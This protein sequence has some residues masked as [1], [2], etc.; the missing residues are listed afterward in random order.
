MSVTTDAAT[1]LEQHRPALTGHCYRMLGSIGDADDAVQETL[2]RAWRSFDRFEGRSSLRHWLV[3]IATHVCLDAL[4]ARARRF[5]AIEL[6]PPGGVDDALGTRPDHDWLEPAPDAAILP[7]LTSNP[8]DPSERALLRESVRLAFVAALQRLPPR[9]RAALLLMEVLGWSA[10]EAAETLSTSVA[11][12]HSATQ[13]A[14]AT[15]GERAPAQPDALSPEQHALLDRYVAAFERY[16]V[17][18]LASLLCEDAVFSMPPHSLWLRGPDSVAA[19]LRGRGRECRGSRL[20][21]TAACG[22]PAFGQYRRA[23]PDGDPAGPERWRPWALVTLELD[24]D[25]IAAWTSFLA[26]D[27]LFPRFGLPALLS[28]D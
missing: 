8:D 14:R 19:W 18:A 6:G 28:A 3:R 22:G 27:V 24:G 13:R 16:D 25:R 26:V 20:V 12:I 2:L 9:Q 10:A 21:A 17:D 1:L 4:S 7:G 11:A 5:R 23:P 15:L